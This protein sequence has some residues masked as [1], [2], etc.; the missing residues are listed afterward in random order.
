MP[1]FYMHLHT[2]AG[3]DADEIGQEFSSASLAIAQA[4]ETAG[5]I[6]RD[7]A[8]DPLDNRELRIDV[9]DEGRARIAQVDMRL[10]ISRPV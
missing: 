3:D 10:T 1:R 7:E 5:E 9:E 4:A 6:M 2:G 8:A